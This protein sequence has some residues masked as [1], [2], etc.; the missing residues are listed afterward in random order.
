MS[1]QLLA[2]L[3]VLIT[4]GELTMNQ[5]FNDILTKICVI[6]DQNKLKYL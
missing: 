6:Y 1:L 3:G 5:K 2:N 4:P